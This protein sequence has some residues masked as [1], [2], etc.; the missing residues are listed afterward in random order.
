MSY[1]ALSPDKIQPYFHIWPDLNA[2]YILYYNQNRRFQVHIGDNVSVW[3][4]QV[5]SLPQGSDLSPTLFNLYTNDLPV[6]CSH[7]FVYADDIYCALQ[8]ETI[9]EI[10]CTLTADLAHLPNT[11]SCGFW[12]PVRPRLY[13]CL[14]TGQAVS[15]MFTWMVN[16]WNTT[17]TQCFLVS[18]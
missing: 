4:R 3:R 10:E 17:P 13:K 8:A 12:N 7:R 18:L 16:V 2:G 14:T 9:S 1:P 6:T 5:N 15:W 11:V